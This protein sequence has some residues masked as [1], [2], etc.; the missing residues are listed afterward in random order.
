MPT[1]LLRNTSLKSVDFISQICFE[2]PCCFDEN[3]SMTKSDFGKNGLNTHNCVTVTI[4]EYHP[5]ISNHSQ[6]LRVLAEIS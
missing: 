3:M 4:R 5:D 2:I 1:F 6:K